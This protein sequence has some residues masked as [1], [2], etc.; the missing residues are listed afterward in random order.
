MMKNRIAKTIATS[1]GFGYAPFGPGTFGTALGLIIYVL[2]ANTF[3]IVNSNTQSLTLNLLLIGLVIIFTWLGTWSA[4]V[5]EPEWGHD[6][7]KI[8]IDETI[9]VWI[10]ILFIPFSWVN[11]LLAFVIFRF[12]DILKPLGIRAIDEKLHSPFSVM[13]DDIVAGIYSAITLQLIVYLF[14]T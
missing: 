14:Q 6:P 7:G 10:T 1:L 11:V 3:D 4:R 2:L 13:L 8:V 12:F 9:G 5:L